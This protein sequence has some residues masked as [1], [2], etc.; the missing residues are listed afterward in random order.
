M[1][2]LLALVSSMFLSIGILAQSINPS[3]VDGEVH[4]KIN[5]SLQLDLD[6]YAGGNL[7]LDLLYS[8][9][10]IDS[11]YRPFPLPGTS[12]DSIYRVSFSALSEIDLLVSGLESL[13]F[14]NY[15]EKIPM[16]FQSYTPNDMDG[17]LW[18]LQ[19][20]Q[21]E[22]GWNHSTG[23]EEV[24]IAIVDNAI[25]IDH[26]DLLP[27]VFVNTEEANGL[28]L[29]D[30]DLNGYAD[31]VN[32]YDLS[33]RDN[34]PRPPSGAIDN[35]S[36]FTH[37]T[38]VA[39]I[40]SAATDNGV[41]IAS[42]G[43]NCSILPV[44]VADDN[45]DGTSFNKSIDGIFYAMQSGAN[46]INMSWG[47][48][49]NSAVLHTVVQQAATEEI[50]LVA[51]AGNEN[52]DEPRYPAAYPEVISV[53]ATDEND[54]RASFSNFGTSIDV[55]APGVSI[56]STL[57]FNDN[58]YGSL[59]GT[60][61]AAPLVSALSGLI[62]A[63]G[64]PPS[65]VKQRIQETCDDISMSNPGMNGLLGAGRIN[66]FQALGNVGI[67]NR[68]SSDDHIDIYPNPVRNGEPLTID[69]SGKLAVVDTRGRLILQRDSK[70][71]SQFTLPSPGAYYAILERQKTTLRATIIVTP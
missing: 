71:R 34:D 10:E 63:Q 4:F 1:R 31:D 47:T 7:A 50:I 12:L 46:V 41:G 13:P 9:Y 32:G 21:A 43:F 45:S 6:N 57:P 56:R 35:N 42:L 5:A 24:V 52:T 20:I 70:D 37:G 59:S 25:A 60:S 49:N 58:T 38:H 3:W 51:A 15:A 48:A 19:I 2:F 29:I 55:M 26:V 62:L 30:D 18:H 64:T 65:S 44:K 66:A 23:S 27:N 14:V 17:D 68:H 22:L 40:A 39:G 67:G 33:N 8:T 54:A 36:S 16:M 28:P 61:M 53:A 11:I 69:A